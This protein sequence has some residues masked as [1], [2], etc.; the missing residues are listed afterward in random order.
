MS[1]GVLAHET[2]NTASLRNLYSYCDVPYTDQKPSLG[3]TMSLK[4]KRPGGETDEIHE[5]CPEEGS[6]P[7][8]KG[9]SRW[10]G[11][12]ETAEGN[13]QNATQKKRSASAHEMRNIFTAPAATTSTIW[14]LNTL[15]G[16]YTAPKDARDPEIKRA[17]FRRSKWHEI[18]SEK[19]VKTREARGGRAETREMRLQDPGEPWDTVRRLLDGHGERGITEIG[20]PD[21]ELRAKRPRCPPNMKTGNISAMAARN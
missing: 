8:N 13:T 2:C 21:P 20:W 7:N 16:W 4:N 19:S 12:A 18:G 17:R 5:Q 10:H 6:P 1:E 14:C 3:S 11:I 15:T 9:R